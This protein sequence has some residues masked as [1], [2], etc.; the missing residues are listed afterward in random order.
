MN[1]S[2]VVIKVNVND[3]VAV[4]VNENRLKKGTTILN[5]IILA[6]D[7]PQGH[8]VALKDFKKGDNVIRYGEVIGHANTLISIG[9]WVNEHNIDLPEAP[10]MD[11]LPIATKSS[12]SPVASLSEHFFQGFCNKDGSVGVKNI[13]GI[14]TSVQ[15]TAAVANNAVKEIKTQLLDQYPNVDDVIAIN[16]AYGCGVAIDAPDAIIP[17]RTLQNIARNPN[18]GDVIILGLGC[19]KLDPKRLVNNTTILEDPVI[20][21]Q[22]EASGGYQGMINRIMDIADRK[23]KRLN[24]RKRVPCSISDLVVGVQC[25]GSDAFSGLT[26]NTAVGYAVD[27]I[28]NAGGTVLFSE[29]TEVRD[30]VHL[31]TPR[32]INQEVGN[33]LIR[34]M[35]WYDNYLKKGGVN[36]SANT[37]PGNK[38]GGLANI[39][40]KALGSIVKSGTTP[41][42]DVLSHGE[43]VR[44]KG[45]IFAA[46]PAS[47]FI[48]GTQQLA[49]GINLQVFTTGRGTPYNLTMAPVIKVSSRLEL[50]RQWFDL[51]DL[52]AGRIANGQG[53]IESVGEELFELILEIASGKKSTCADKLN[54]A[55]DLVIFNPAPVT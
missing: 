12:L 21:L 31:L 34:E 49:S 44:K 35:K 40:E 16:H 53:T 45:L 13:L 33:S 10:S 9:S 23:L 4:V 28:V 30:A 19:E 15:C 20:N 2:P 29:N 25:G 8:K 3:N 27:M 55:N 43:K 18:L 48:C 42:V 41:I 52:D 7:I 54:L 24:D 17:I 6:E 47:D 50:S 1:V 14:V 46:T 22:S 36:R 39:L 32:A 5:N 38:K 26:A 11:S 51:I 37:T